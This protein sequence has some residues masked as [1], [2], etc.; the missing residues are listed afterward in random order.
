MVSCCPNRTSLRLRPNFCSGMKSS[1]TS[2][3]RKKWI[4]G[5]EVHSRVHVLP[6][7]GEPGVSKATADK[8]R[9]RD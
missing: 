5:H 6:F 1:Q 2:E 8:V 4:D 7:F 3:R 9:D